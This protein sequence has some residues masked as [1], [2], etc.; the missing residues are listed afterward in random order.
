MTPKHHHDPF[1]WKTFKEIA[2]PVG[3]SIPR[4]LRFMKDAAAGTFVG[5]CI[6]AP[7]LFAKGVVFL[8]VSFVLFLLLLLILV[9]S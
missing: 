1:L 5:I 4:L 7:L 9:H 2:V 3:R 8:S 6:N